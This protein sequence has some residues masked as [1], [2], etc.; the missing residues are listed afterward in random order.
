[1]VFNTPTMK[2]LELLKCDDE[3]SKRGV[4]YYS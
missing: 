1:M 3:E 2:I 4:S